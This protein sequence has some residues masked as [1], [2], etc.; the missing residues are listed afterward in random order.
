V[1]G[2][3]NRV[4][5]KALNRTGYP[6]M[7]DGKIVDENG[8]EITSVQTLHAG[9]GVFAHV[10]E[11][12]KRYFLECRNENGLEKLF[13]LPKPDPRARALTVVQNNNRI[14][15]GIRMSPRISSG[16]DN[17]LYLLAQ[18]RGEALYFSEWD[19]KNDYLPFSTEGFPSGIIQFVLFDE[20]M[21]P[22]SERLVFN[23]NFQ[24]D[25]ENIEFQTDNVSYGK[26][27]KVIATVQLPLT[28]PKEGKISS[29]PGSVGV[30]LSVAI[31][32]DRD[33]APDS[34]T[35][36]LSS[37]LLASELKGYIEN[38]AWYLQDNIQSATALDYLMMTHGWRRYNVPGVVRGN[39]EAPQVPFQTGQQISGKVRGLFSRPVAGS[40]VI[41]VAEGGGY[42]IAS[43][44]GKGTFMFQ[45]FEYPDSTS[46]MIQAFS[47]RVKLDMD[48]ES[49]PKPVHAPRP[50]PVETDNYP[51][52]NTGNFFA[53][54]EQRMKYDR[55]MRVI[56][57][58]EVVVSAPRIDRKK[59]PRLEFWLNSS[60]NYTVR[61]EQM[62]RVYFPHIAQYLMYVPG[63]KVTP[64]SQNPWHYHISLCGFCGNPVFLV[65]G[66]YVDNL[67]DIPPDMIES[68]DV[69]KFASASAMGMRGANGVVSLTTRRGGETNTEIEKFNQTVY[70]PTGYQKPVEFYA[71]KYE[72][73]ETKNLATPDYRTTIFWKP[74]VVIPDGQEEASFEFYTSD[75][76][77][78][79]SVVIE[80]LTTD[81]KIIRQVEKIR[82][83]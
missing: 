74:D 83:E 79:Y 20:R 82:V 37:L 7:I 9:M 16:Q 2:I 39:L 35:T 62:D 76:P 68:I 47:N 48:T 29:L 59:E 8:N 22:L 21:N 1:E 55:D 19:Q 73:L 32:D 31:T 3:W 25:V 18:C 64:D 28:P 56:Y 65:D 41:I 50:A 67:D 49:F 53:K 61:R 14:S 38:P 6:E 4:A 40:E 72:T 17:P 52:L 23:K 42:G 63:A 24:N 54:A 69:L 36:I 10:P 75:F 45:G 51:S 13:D 34:A 71:P 70:T 66:V 81:G 33:I 15:A 43:T 77:T 46:F 26:R 5:L 57:L 44:D 58:D 12:G 11:S 78:T 30:E 27:G 80:G 60:A